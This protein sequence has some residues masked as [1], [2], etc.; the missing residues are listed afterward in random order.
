[1]N[2]IHSVQFKF[3]S[4]FILKKAKFSFLLSRY[5]ATGE[6]FRSL[7]FAFRTDHSTIS[8]LARDLAHAIWDHLAEEH[9]QFPNAAQKWKAIAKDFL[10]KWQFPLCLGAL[11]GKHVVI[12]APN[13]SRSEYFN[14]KGTF[15]VVLMALVDANL[16]FIGID[17][18]APGRFSDGGIFSNS[19][20]GKG[21]LNGRFVLPQ[22][23]P[24]PEAEH[25]GSL[26]Y[27][28]VA[29]EAFP[30]KDCIMRPYLGRGQSHVQRVYN[31]RHSRAR[32][33]SKNAF[34]ALASRWRFSHTKIATVPDLTVATV[35]A[36]CVLHN[37]LVD[38]NPNLTS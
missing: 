7:A 30:L 36:A 33:V 23:E 17:V 35:K 21:F 15:S 19:N 4:S 24:L 1:M 2:S 13:H 9:F 38:Q 5:L 20:L 12:M 28:L 26:P 6:S 32:R 3:S 11:D 34:G 27:V 22:R 14:Y 37:M 25:L 31:Y 8:N 16:K 10:E 18:G 29:D